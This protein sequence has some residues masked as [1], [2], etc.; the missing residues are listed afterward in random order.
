LAISYPRAH[1][2]SQAQASSTPVTVLGTISGNRGSLA[3]VHPGE[4]AR[5]QYVKPG[6]TVTGSGAR[7]ESI[8]PGTVTI[9]GRGGSRELSVR[10]RRSVPPAPAAPAATPKAEAS[11]APTPE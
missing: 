7:V 2:G 3:V 1:R 8:S 11:A 9:G 10:A 4:A 6:D 5:G